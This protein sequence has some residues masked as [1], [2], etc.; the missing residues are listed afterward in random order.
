MDYI[1]FER[2]GEDCAINEGGT[3]TDAGYIR[4]TGD[5]WNRYFDGTLEDIPD[6]YRVTGSGEELEPVSYTHLD[7]YKRQM[8]HCGDPIQYTS[9]N[10]SYW[11][12]HF[13]AFGRP[14]Y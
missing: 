6:E 2:Y 7:V 11:Q 13:Y 10:T 14:N 3:L 8:L 9:I 1:D 4:P 12:S 5:S